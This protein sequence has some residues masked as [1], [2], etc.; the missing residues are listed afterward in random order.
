M[1]QN[2]CK[3]MIFYPNNQKKRHK[4]HKSAT[5][6]WFRLGVCYKNHTYM[7]CIV[8]QGKTSKILL[9]SVWRSVQYIEQT[10]FIEQKSISA[11]EENGMLLNYKSKKIEL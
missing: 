11:N 7:T 5:F 10:V 3:G 8:V 4:K 1:L 6:S 9:C 2:Q